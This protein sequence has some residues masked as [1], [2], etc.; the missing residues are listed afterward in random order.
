[1]AKGVL[2]FD[3][4]SKHQTLKNQIITY[5]KVDIYKRIDI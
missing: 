1:M 4:F 2:T 5:V 3:L